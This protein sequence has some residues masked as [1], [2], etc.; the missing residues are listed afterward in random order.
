MR[1]LLRLALAAPLAALL[2][3]APAGPVE[4]GC[5]CTKPPPPPA[6]V[7][8]A[9]TWSGAEVT[10][11]D[12][13]LV[14]GESYWVEFRSA[15]PVQS[16]Q[17]TATAVLRRDLADG[18]MRPQL[19]VQ[20]PV[21]PLGPARI[22]VVKL[23]STHIMTLSDDAF[24][25]APQPV[26]V[27]SGVGT[28]R[29][30]NYRA[31]VSRDGTAYLSLDFSDVQH[32]RVFDARAE[33]WPLRF[34]N[35]GLAF[36]NA[37]GFLMQLLGEGMPGLF[38]ISAAGTADSD[39]LHY[40]RHEFNTYFLQHEER[41]NHAVDPSDPNWHQ[42]GTP[43]IDHN[44]QLLA[45]EGTLAGGTPAPGASAP[46]TLVVETE[47]FFQHGVVGES[48][49]LVDHAQVR[50]YDPLLG[51]LGLH[52]D[53]LSNGLVTVKNNGVVYGDATA[54]DFVI[55]TGG[56]VVGHLHG[57]GPPVSFLPVAAPTGLVSLGDL[58]IEGPMVLGPGSY[59]AKKIEVRAGGHLQIQNADGP[60]TVYVS[61]DFLVDDGATVQTEDIDP[62][63]FAVYVLA[64]GTARFS[65]GGSFFGVV[66][67][68]SARV[69]VDHGGTLAGAAVGGV[70]E[71]KDDA[72]VFYDQ[73]LH[74]NDC[75]P[76]P[77]PLVLP[78]TDDVEPGRLLSLPGLLDEALGG[79]ALRVGGL[80]VPLLP[81]VLG[82]LVTLPQDLKPGTDVEFTLVDP[83]GCRT[84]RTRMMH[85]E[86]EEPP[87]CGL[88]GIEFLLAYPLA[89]ALRRVRRAT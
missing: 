60:V 15:S 55:N 21:L 64:D 54:D 16:S 68:P 45:I 69:K 4:A 37:Q 89:R 75:P 80:T 83:N 7:R 24:T 72:T 58:R 34:G 8:P 19:V 70:V 57:A 79:Y 59:S 46:F 88:L 27:P 66:Y 62:E 23:P 52:G 50:S 41:Q 67:G 20:L 48:S 29:F 31:A 74:R 28:Y 82:A 51:L 5:G 12:D 78:D 61:D 25:V 30:E 3:V 22:R 77:P 85:V 32:A 53:V 17:L 14:A 81:S 10:L 40:S 13:A 63:K 49:V 47:T 56:H 44:H 11:F 33:G 35:D 65:D 18:A 84:W 42:D 71:V 26:G 38:A 1:I 87:H 36:Y 2:S 86:D 6:A 76:N 43:H 9:A 73:R 39:V